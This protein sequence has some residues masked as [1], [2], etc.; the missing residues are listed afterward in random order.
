[1]RQYEMDTDIKCIFLS[2]SQSEYLWWRQMRPLEPDSTHTQHNTHHQF[3][4][5]QSTT[6]RFFGFEDFLLIGEFSWMFQSLKMSC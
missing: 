2:A 5:P 1:M 4:Q 6:N 3:A